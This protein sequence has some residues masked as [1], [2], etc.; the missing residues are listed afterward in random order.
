MIAFESDRIAGTLVKVT[1]FGLTISNYGRTH[2]TV[3]GDALPVRYLPPESLQ[4]RRFSEKSDVWAF[5]VTGYEIYSNGL[6]PFFDIASDNAVITHVCNGGRLPRLQSCPENVWTV[7]KMCWSVQPLNRPT[8]AVL[9]TMLG[10]VAPAG[11][12]QQQIMQQQQPSVNNRALAPLT[13]P[14]RVTPQSKSPSLPSGWEEIMGPAPEKKPLYCHRPSKCQ[15]YIHPQDQ[16]QEYKRMVYDEERNQ[17]RI[18]D[19]R[20]RHR[21]ISIA[22]HALWG[23]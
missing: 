16:T 17:R 19:N 3:A 2:A 4:R 20:E 15:T 12:Q 10:S 1:D 6:V 18:E 14:T 5:A 23:R 21:Q 11:Q 13:L 9:A 22:N 7:L 8:F